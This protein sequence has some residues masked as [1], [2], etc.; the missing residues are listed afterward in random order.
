[1]KKATILIVDDNTT[2]LNVL[3][4]YLHE[5]GY[6]VLIVPVVNKPCSRCS[7]SAPILFC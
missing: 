2:N 3:L 4:D 7:M 5:V 1:M 6:K